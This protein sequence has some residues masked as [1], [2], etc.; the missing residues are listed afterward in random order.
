[1][2]FLFERRLFTSLVSMRLT[3]LVAT[4]LLLVKP[5]LVLVREAPMARFTHIG[6]QGRLEVLST[7]L[8]RET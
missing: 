3:I 8:T 5:S 2:T 6:L 1:M 4:I 7:K